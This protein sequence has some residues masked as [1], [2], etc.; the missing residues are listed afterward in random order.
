MI[1]AMDREQKP[2]KERKSLEEPP[3]FD[4]DPR[5][6]SFRERGPRD[7]PVKEFKRVLERMSREK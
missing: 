7:D 1:D 5:L 3:P 4:P 6:A 2:T